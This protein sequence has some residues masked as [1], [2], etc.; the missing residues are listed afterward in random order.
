[1]WRSHRMRSESTG[2]VGTCARSIGTPRH[3]HVIS[4]RHNR[5]AI[6][7][8]TAFGPRYIHAQHF[9]L[10][11][12]RASRSPILTI[13]SLAFVGVQRWLVQ[14]KW[15]A[16]DG[17]CA[18]GH[19][20]THSARAHPSRL[21]SADNSPRQTR[22]GPPSP[23]SPGCF[24]LSPHAAYCACIS[25]PWEAFWLRPCTLCHDS[26]IGLSSQIC[27]VVVV[28]MEG[29]AADRSQGWCT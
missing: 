10:T 23:P 12:L 13:C 20:N 26:T 15:G 14:S 9:S 17:P 27:F 8:R 24:I 22:H 7:P 19:C 29:P 28:G 4:F 16:A 3:P 21:V 2:S 25:V 1:M 6:K 11:C 5:L 18:V